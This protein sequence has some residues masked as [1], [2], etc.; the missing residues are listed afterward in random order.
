MLCVY[1]VTP[2]THPGVALDGVH[3]QPTHVVRRGDFAAIVSTLDGALVARRRDVNA[4]M[5]VLEAAFRD[6]DVLPYQFGT[7]VEDDAA[8]GEVL[9]RTAPQLDALLRRVSGRVQMTVKIVRDDDA[10]VRAAVDSDNRLRRVVAAQRGSSDWADRAALGERVAVAVERLSHRDVASIQSRLEPHAEEMTS[11]PAT[12]PAVALLAL[13][14]HPD[15]LHQLDVT[16]AEL[17]DEFTDRLSLDY[18]GL[19]PPYSFVR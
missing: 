11:T 12:A 7:V 14:V 15:R 5:S 6:G 17:R 3:A 8:M 4:H 2:A 18:A 9:E 1:G 10:A 13:L 19:M 16:V